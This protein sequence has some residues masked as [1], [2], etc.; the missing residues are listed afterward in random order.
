MEMDA[1]KVDV[2]DVTLLVDCVLVLDVDYA[3]HQLDVMDVV[4]QLAE[5]ELELSVELEMDVTDAVVLD[6]LDVDVAQSDAVY[7]LA[8]MDAAD[9]NLLIFDSK[10]KN[11]I[12]S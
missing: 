11:A 2:T 9:Q 4:V 7:L 12:L 8:A 10:S 1:V 6:V 3:V 5:E